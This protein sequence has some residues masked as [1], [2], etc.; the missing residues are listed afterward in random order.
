MQDIFFFIYGIYFKCRRNL[1]SLTAMSEPRSCSL[2][3]RKPC[4]GKEQKEREKKVQTNFQRHKR[5]QQMYS[6][7]LERDEPK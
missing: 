4:D 3:H 1:P 5:D 7:R 2:Y 6:K